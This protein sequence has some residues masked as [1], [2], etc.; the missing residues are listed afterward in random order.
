MCAG[1]ALC[2]DSRVSGAAASQSSVLL[3]R[4]INSEPSWHLRLDLGKH[5]YRLEKEKGKSKQARSLFTM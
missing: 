3:A 2:L 5:N 4:E 1:L